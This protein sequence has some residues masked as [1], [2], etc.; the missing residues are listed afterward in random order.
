M[1]SLTFIVALIV[2]IPTRASNLP[3]QGGPR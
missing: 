1:A 3:L 2:V